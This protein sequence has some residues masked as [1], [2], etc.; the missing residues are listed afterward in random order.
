[1]KYTVYSVRDRLVGFGALL[2]DTSPEN[3]KRNFGMAMATN[4]ACDDYDLY[5]IAEYDTET[6]F[7]K[8]FSVPTLVLKGRDAAYMYLPPLDP[9]APSLDEFV[10]RKPP[11]KRKSS[12]KEDV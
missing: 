6:G 12:S 11:R 1:M 8:P 2:P 7:I 9:S 10:S 4:I 3:A 5:S